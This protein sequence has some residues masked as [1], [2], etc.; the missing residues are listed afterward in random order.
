MAETK[1]PNLLDRWPPENG[2]QKTYELDILNK[3][4]DAYF[5]TQWDRTRVQLWW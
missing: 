1:D 5:Y 4:W 3:V 2:R